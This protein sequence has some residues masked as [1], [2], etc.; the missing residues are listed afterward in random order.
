MT[1]G[2]GRR[3][4]PTSQAAWRFG[5]ALQAMGFEVRHHFTDRWAERAISRGVRAGPEI[6]ARWFAAGQ[7]YRDT[8]PNQHL[9]FAVTPIGVVAYRVGGP[10]GGRIVLI[11]LVGSL[12]PGAARRQSPRLVGGR[13]V[14]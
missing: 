4:S 2:R 10:N 13:V 3:S 8:R 5:R 1:R 9:S 6:L 14:A 11:T 7:H 12:P